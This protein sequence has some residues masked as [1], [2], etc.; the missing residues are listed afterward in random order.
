MIAA[1]MIDDPRLLIADEPTTAL[2]VLIQEQIIELLRRINR[3]RGTAVLFISHDLSLVN[4]LC[5]RVLVMHH[6]KVIETGRSSEVFQNP[7][8]DYTKKLIASIPRVNLQRP[9]DNDRDVHPEVS[10]APTGKNALSVKDL[11]VFYTSRGKGFFGRT[12]KTEVV[13]HVSLDVGEGEILALVGASGSGKSTLARAV[14]GLNPLHTGTIELPDGRPQMV[15]QDPYNSL[16]PAY[17]IRWLLEEP[18]RL[19]GVNDEKERKKRVDEMMELVHLDKTLGDRYPSQLSGGQ[20]QRVCIGS[21]LMQKPKLLIA[22][23]PVS[24]LDVTIQVEILSLLKRL[25]RELGLA[26]LFISHDLRTVWQLCDRV[27]IMKDGLIV[28]Q[29]DVDEIYLHSQSEYTKQL[30]QAACIVRREEQ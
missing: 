29:G 26:V 14:A 2:D 1:A 15:F 12:Q 5:S 17:T 21:A 9:R 4:R 27:A 6:G 30:L 25:Q 19:A 7:N 28:D 18:L 11:S 13:H 16:N 20:R 24:A 23:E 8:R 22:D 10:P 3:E